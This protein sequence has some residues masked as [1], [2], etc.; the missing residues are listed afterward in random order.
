[1][2][3][4]FQLSHPKKKVARLVDAVRCDVKKYLKRERKKDLSEGVDYWDFDCKFGPS[5]ELA[6]VIEVADIGKAIDEA[7]K[8]QFETI[9]VEILAKPGHR[10]ERDN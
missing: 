8:Q 7:E 1:M 3:K 10:A 9:Y 6:E 2:K 4:T 5:A